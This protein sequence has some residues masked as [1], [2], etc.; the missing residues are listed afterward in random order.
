MQTLLVHGT[1]QTPWILRIHWGSKLQ[2]L[3]SLSTVESEYISLSYATRQVLFILH[4]LEELKE[5]KI[6][7]ELPIANVYA[8]CFE[9]NTGCLDLAKTPKLRPRT[10]HIAVKYHHF[11]SYVRSKENPS[12]IL[13]LHWVSTDKQQADIFTKPLP[14]K[15]FLALRRLI[16]GW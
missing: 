1:E 12:G 9:D 7:F 2:D 3:V 4:L 6:D 5:N 15:T 10:K 14:P 11:R 13:E 8:K 16:C